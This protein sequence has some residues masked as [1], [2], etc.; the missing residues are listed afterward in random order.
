MGMSFGWEAGRDMT[1]MSGG[2]STGGNQENVWGDSTGS[3]MSMLTGGNKVTYGLLGLAATF[4]VSAGIVW[5]R[6]RK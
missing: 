5:T 2:E 3:K 6:K 1:T 4:F